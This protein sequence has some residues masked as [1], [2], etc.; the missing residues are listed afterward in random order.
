MLHVVLAFGGLALTGLA[1]LAYEEP[2]A[3]AKM[4]PYLIVAGIA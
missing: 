3:Y 4:F 2:V 1:Y